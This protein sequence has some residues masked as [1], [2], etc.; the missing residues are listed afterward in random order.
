MLRNENPVNRKIAAGF[1]ALGLGLA[2]NV[3]NAPDMDRAFAR[4]AETVQYDSF[5]A[6][7]NY[8]AKAATLG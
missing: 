1:A 3:S 6:V 4:S 2:A 7:Q 8:E 5:G